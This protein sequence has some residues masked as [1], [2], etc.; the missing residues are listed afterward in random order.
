M[1]K[2]KGWGVGVLL[3]GVLLAGCTVETPTPSTAAVPS[4]SAVASPVPPTASATPLPTAVPSATL[5]PTP[6]PAAHLRLQDQF[7]DS[8]QTCFQ[9]FNTEQAV[10]EVV[11]GHYLLTI[12][13][14]AYI[15]QVVCESWVLSDFIYEVDIELLALPPESDFFFGVIFRVSGYEHYAVVLGSQENYCLYY[16]KEGAYTY[17]TNGTDFDVPCWVALPPIDWD[18]GQLHLRV[19]TAGTRQEVYLNGELLAVVHDGG[20]Q[21]GWFGFVAGTG[22]AGGLSISYDNLVVWTEQ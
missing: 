16:A 9:Q 5:P 8:Q 7:N 11:D 21:Q 1:A 13:A 15:A 22:P 14:P 10:A 2:F 6:T 17:L 18:A 12:S 20:L 4:E 19:V 3:C